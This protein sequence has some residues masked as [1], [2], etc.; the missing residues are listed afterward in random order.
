M[1]HPHRRGPWEIK[2]G[3]R[4]ARDSPKPSLASREEA[5]KIPEP[6]RR[7]NPKGQAPQDH[8]SPGPNPDVEPTTVTGPAPPPETTVSV[9]PT[10]PEG[11]PENGAQINAP[12]LEAQGEPEPTP[13]TKAEE[14]KE[15]TADDG[16]STPTSAPVKTKKK[17]K[18]LKKKVDSSSGDEEE[19]EKAW[20][21]VK[22]QR[23]RERCRKEKEERDERR[24]A[25]IN[26]K[27]SPPEKNHRW[28]P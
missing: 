4:V 12:P 16:T 15:S 1:E 3:R 14:G 5:Q 20:K 26:G 7:S 21:Q 23:L 9:V 19:I 28:N 17:N 22:S 10:H 18:H 25:R 11:T 8:K 2:R 13:G 27:Q 6:T 24:R